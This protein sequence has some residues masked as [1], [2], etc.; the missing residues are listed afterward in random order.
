MKASSHNSD[1][2]ALVLR[3]LQTCCPLGISI[4]HIERGV[5]TL[6][7]PS[8]AAF[9]ISEEG[10]IRSALLIRVYARDAN[11]DTCCA[12]HVDKK[13]ANTNR[14]GS[15]S[16]WIDTSRLGCSAARHRSRRVA[17][18]GGSRLACR[19]AHLAIVS[20]RIYSGCTRQR[21]GEIGNRCGCDGSRVGIE[22][23]RHDEADEES[24]DG[25]ANYPRVHR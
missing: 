12:A 18:D 17:T 20:R 10:F 14:A 9:G 25:D 21:I 23:Q 1:R 22:G 15:R 5:D 8:A 24:A 3:E 16:G 7:F 13:C 4:E 2:D 19:N 11:A 6:N